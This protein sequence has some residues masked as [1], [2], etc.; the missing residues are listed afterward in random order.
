MND[1]P[2]GLLLIPLCIAI[3]GLPFLPALLAARKP[4]RSTT[5]AQ[6]TADSSAQCE[7]FRSL[8][9]SRFASLINLA[10]TNGTIRGTNDHGQPYI[11]LGFQSHLAQYLSP[12]SRRLRSCVIASGHLD[13][14]GELVCD[15]ELFAEGRIN[16][17][18]HALAKAMLSHRDIAIG[19]RA[20][21]THWV[22]SDRRLDIAEAASIKGWASAGIEVVLARRARFRKVLAPEIR[23]G[24]QREAGDARNAHD[25]I[26][27]FSPPARS[28]EQ[29]GNG[30][31]LQI[32][33]HHTMKGDLV[34]SGVLTVGDG[35]HLIGRIRADKG[36]V[37]GQDV[38]VEGAIHAGGDIRIG[39][40]CSIS[41]P[42]IS[43]AGIHADPGCVFGSRED[44]CTV[45][46]ETILIGE[47]SLAHGTVHALRHGEV[48]AERSGA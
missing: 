21:V 7:S 9:E 31:H 46:A 29:P 25:T 15:R 30:H 14:P 8:V 28:G 2:D 36:I 18:H 1:L 47:A 23:F 33:A 24:R 27:A 4:P 40:R 17:G 10:R 48:L 34:L 43:S 11:V 37:L 5:G 39:A 42:V 6:G 35:C 3:C 19:P 32:P 12:D 41:G 38:R 13:V 22:R 26:G 45:S 44:P 16:L 20:R